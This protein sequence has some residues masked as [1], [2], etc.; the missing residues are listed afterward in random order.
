MTEENV[1]ALRRLTDL[2][3]PLYMPPRP[4]VPGVILAGSLWAEFVSP[5]P[6]MPSP[7]CYSV[8]RTTSAAAGS[9]TADDNYV[10]ASR[11]SG[12]EGAGAKKL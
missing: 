11:P 4:V 7:Q 1:D 12:E 10:G 5:P 8:N 9:T 6:Q 3:H 2:S